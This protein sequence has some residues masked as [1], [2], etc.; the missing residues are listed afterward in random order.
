MVRF[1]CWCLLFLCVRELVRRLA[2]CGDVRRGPVYDA[3]IVR[4][5]L[6]R[7]VAYDLPIVAVLGDLVCVIAMFDVDPVWI[8]EAWSNG[9]LALSAAVGFRHD[10]IA[11]LLLDRG[12]D[13]TWPDTYNSSHNSTLHTTAGTGN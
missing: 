13:P 9:Q 8:C 12:A 4:L 1:I 11:R 3:A 6:A 10:R 7:G 2:L 5:L